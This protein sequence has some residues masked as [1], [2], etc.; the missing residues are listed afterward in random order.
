ME[1]RE[2]SRKRRGVKEA[3]KEGAGGELVGCVER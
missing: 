2:G 1:V 3:C